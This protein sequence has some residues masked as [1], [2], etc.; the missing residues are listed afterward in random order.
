M[1]YTGAVGAIE[2]DGRK[3]K[4]FLV[5]CIEQDVAG[6]TLI[7]DWV[8]AVS[9]GPLDEVP[10]VIL[11]QEVTDTGAVVCAGSTDISITAV[12]TRSITFTKMSATVPASA[13]AHTYRIILLAKLAGEV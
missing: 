6:E 1:A 11:C 13:I 8:T 9:M 12:T 5:T 3:S 4:V 2:T 7:Y 10:G